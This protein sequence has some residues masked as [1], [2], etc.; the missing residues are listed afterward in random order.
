MKSTAAAVAEAEE[1]RGQ[2]GVFV[3]ALRQMFDCIVLVAM[4]NMLD[5]QRAINCCKNDTGVLIQR[6]AVIQKQVL[7]RGNFQHSIIHSKLP[8][9]ICGFALTPA[10]LSEELSCYRILQGVKEQKQ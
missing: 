2:E 8:I 1:R 7:D 5:Q 3:R 4:N 6:V 10:S 9:L